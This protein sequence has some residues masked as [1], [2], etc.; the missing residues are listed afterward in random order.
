MTTS[1]YALASSDTQANTLVRAFKSAGFR[2]D[3]ISVIFPHK[4][5]TRDFA[6]EE[7]TRA[8]EGALAGGATGSVVGGALGWMA[9]IGLLAVPG[10]GP[11]IAAGPILAALSGAA[12]GAAFGGLAGLFIGMGMTEHEAKRYEGKVREG[13]ILVSI[14]ADDS[15]GASRAK[16]IFKD[17]G[18]EDISSSGEA[19]S[20]DTKSPAGDQSPQ[21]GTAEARAEYR[22]PVVL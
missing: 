13:R 18:A 10:V 15:D 12:V 16:Q 22:S 6:Q 4:T 21:A 14:Q 2:Y 8:P 3:D 17:G 5:S 19:T 20:A 11:F 9:S 7:N 1:V